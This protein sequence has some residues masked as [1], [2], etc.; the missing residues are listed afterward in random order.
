MSAALGG[1]AGGLDTTTEPIGRGE[2]VEKLVNDFENRR[3][4]V[5]AEVVGYI[6]NDVLVPENQWRAGIEMGRFDLDVVRGLME[7]SLDAAADIAMTRE[8]IV[9]DRE[10]AERTFYDT[11]H[12]RC[13]VPFLIC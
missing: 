6:L 4:G 13:A 2:F 3:M 5:E 9:I 1:G 8:R 12:G 11:I 10:L 7:E